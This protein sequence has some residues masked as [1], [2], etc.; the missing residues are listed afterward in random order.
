MR[1]PVSLEVLNTA[2]TAAQRTVPN[3][4][5]PSLNVTAPDG[6]PAPETAAVTLAVKV[7]LLPDLAGFSEE[8]RV[9]RELTLFTI[10][11][12]PRWCCHHNCHPRYKQP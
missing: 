5:G 9:V 1:S 2:L 8:V 10:W 3:V 12:Q 6:L 11:L 7:T 4:T